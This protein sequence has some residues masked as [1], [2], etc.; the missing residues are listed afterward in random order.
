[1][2]GIFLNFVCNHVQREVLGMVNNQLLDEF[3]LIFSDLS[4]EK[5]LYV[6]IGSSGLPLAAYLSH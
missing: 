4:G 3:T 6:D 1:M 2:H 5:S